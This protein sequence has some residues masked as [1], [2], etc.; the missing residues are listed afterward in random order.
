MKEWFDFIVTLENVKGLWLLRPALPPMDIGR[1]N[2]VATG[3][4]TIQNLGGKKICWAGGVAECFDCRCGK[5]CKFQ[6]LKQLLK[7][8]RF[9]GILPMKNVTLL[10]LSSKYR[11]FIFLIKEEKLWNDYV[12]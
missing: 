8:T 7:T 6:N 2:L 10:L 11:R 4:V 9:I 1:K 3:H 5:L 12:E